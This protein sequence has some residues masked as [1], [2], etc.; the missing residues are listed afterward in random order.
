MGNLLSKLV[1]TRTVEEKAFTVPPWWSNPWA[2]WTD[3][4]GDKESIGIDFGSYI[5]RAY[6]ANGIVFACIL[7]RLLAFSEARFVW[8]QLQN[9]RPTRLFGDDRLGILERP[10]PGATTGE[11]LARMEQDA[12]LAGNSFNTT[13]GSGDSRRLRRLRPSWVTIVA[14][15]EDDDPHALDAK[16]IGYM[17]AP[18]GNLDKAEVLTPDEVAHYSPIPDPDAQFRGMSWLTPILR[19]IESDKSA[20]KH[21]LNFFRNGAVPQVVVTYD[22]A[23][24]ASAFERFVELFREKHE[25]VDNHYKTLHLAGGADAKVVGSNLQQLDLK[26]SQGTLETRIAAAAGVH[27]IIAGLSEGLQGSSLNQGNFDAAKRRFADLTI[28]PLWRIAAASLATIVPSGSSGVQLWYDDRDVPFLR[29]DAKA[30]SEILEKEAQTIAT[31]VREGF[32]A[33]TAVDAVVSGD[34]RRLVGKHSG[35][36]SVQLQPAGAASDELVGSQ[37]GN[38]TSLS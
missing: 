34:L 30:A 19:E 25:G 15:S 36:Y 1:G 2:S 18:G 32:D 21:K 26:A 35:L 24:G 27:P 3:L 33:D 14:G 16:V 20:T 4:A 5:E 31:L 8:R 17:Y 11:L 9:G 28:R 29:E 37:N 10:W 7:A 12:S 6:K 13:V 23:V 38:G 22:K